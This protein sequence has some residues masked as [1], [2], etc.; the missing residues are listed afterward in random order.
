MMSDSQTAVEPVFIPPSTVK[1]EKTKYKR[2][3]SARKGVNGPDAKRSRR[4]SW[5][6]N[7]SSSTDGSPTSSAPADLPLLDGDNPIHVNKMSQRRKEIAKGK[8]TLGYA[9]YTELIPIEK[10]K[11]FSMETPATPDHRLDIPNKRWNGM[12]KAW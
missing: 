3:G 4:N 8:N 12:V 2:Q 1:T 5:S 7:T 6:R 9:R 10:R 11:P